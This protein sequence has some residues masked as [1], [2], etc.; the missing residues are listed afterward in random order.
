MH[1]SAEIY[2]DEHSLF[3]KH[4]KALVCTYVCMYVRM[5]VCMYVCM[6]VCTYV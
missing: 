3:L 2:Q 1:V 6:C 4:D 5:Y